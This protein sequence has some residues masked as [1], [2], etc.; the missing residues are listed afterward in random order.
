MTSKTMYNNSLWDTGRS[1]NQNTRP[2]TQG[3]VSG[4]LT[5]RTLDPY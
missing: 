4:R 1:N 3:D 2:Y 5:N